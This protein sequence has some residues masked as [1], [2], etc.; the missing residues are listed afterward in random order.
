M[1][2]WLRMAA[3]GLMVQTALCEKIAT[4]G[5]D[6]HKSSPSILCQIG[7]ELVI[8]FPILPMLRGEERDYASVATV[9]T[10][11]MNLKTSTVVRQAS[12]RH[13]FCTVV[14]ACQKGSP[15]RVHTRRNC[16][17]P[18][19]STP[20]LVG[21]IWPVHNARHA[22]AGPCTPTPSRKS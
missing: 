22:G 20:P 17:A 6:N 13:Q 16:S 14:N 18:L 11:A 1:C 21:C 19:R 5:F 9:L 15:D 3:N 12:M 2:V 7:H 10:A 8:G 4:L